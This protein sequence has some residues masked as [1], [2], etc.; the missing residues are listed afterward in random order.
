MLSGLQGQP[1]CRQ[2][3]IDSIGSNGVSR[4]LLNHVLDQLSHSQQQS[5]LDER[6]SFG[7]LPLHYAAGYGLVDACQVIL[8]RM[9][10]AGLAHVPTASGAVLLQDSEGYNPL[11]LAV[12]GGHTAA[13][14]TLLDFYNLNNSADQM[15]D[16]PNLDA[17]L[18]GLLAIALKS[19]SVEIV[20]LL[21]ATNV[22]IDY[23]GTCGETALYIAAR[24][25]RED[26]VKLLLNRGADVNAVETVC[27][28]TPLFIACVQGHLS[29]VEHLLQAGASQETRDPSGWTARDHAAYRGHIK[30]AERL[31]ASDAGN[32]ASI[33]SS[34]PGRA[35]SMVPAL[36]PTSSIQPGE[37]VD[38]S[39]SDLPGTSVRH[40]PISE[41][42]VI[43]N[44]CS[45]DTYKDVTA[46]DLSPYLSRNGHPMHPESGFSVQ[47]SAIGA[48]GTNNAVQLPILEDMTNRPWLFSTKDPSG[49]KLVFNISREIT[50]ADGR[51][52]IAPVG[53]GIALLES[54]KHG[55]GSNRESLI[56]DYSIPILEKDTLK[57]IGT[58]TFSFVIVTPFSHP[59][60]TPPAADALWSE[61]GPTKVVGHR[62]SSFCSICP[63]S[64]LICTKDSARMSHPTNA[65]SWERI[66]YR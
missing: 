26:F 49:V 32:S 55:L 43:V 45:F 62:G 42:R 7:R 27:G 14:K 16:L 6:D 66:Q 48:S 4:P 58:V 65:C 29:I 22:N 41:C 39:A 35:G 23:Q 28:W 21:V 9:Q 57:F 61:H 15:V 10:G 25:G 52:R 12:I 20:Q 3:S 24:S 5:S 18:G 40:P 59:E 19:H 33:P 44:L 31:R 53:S 37:G 64:I 51:D 17:V 47:V 38:M 1:T 30:V 34:V 46:V 8:T 11:H 36:R 56:R 63:L 13:T 50:D 60:I 2:D 54:L